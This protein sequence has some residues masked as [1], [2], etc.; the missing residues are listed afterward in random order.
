MRLVVLLSLLV[1]VLARTVQS[2]RK[3]GH[4]QEQSQPLRLKVL[5][6]PSGE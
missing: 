1:C 3:A 2:S 6:A 5:A 4:A